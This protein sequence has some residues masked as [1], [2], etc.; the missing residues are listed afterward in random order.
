M[1]L[2]KFLAQFLVIER[3]SVVLRLECFD[4]L[5]LE[6]HF[7]LEEEIK[8]LFSLELQPEFVDG[9]D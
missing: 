4:R 8:L 5:G 2:L 3:C 9:Q 1:L 6:V 7:L